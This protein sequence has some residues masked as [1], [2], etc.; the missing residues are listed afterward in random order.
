M[1]LQRTESRVS[2]RQ[3]TEKWGVGGSDVD[4]GEAARAVTGE[5]SPECRGG[6]PPSLREDAPQAS[7]L[8]T[9]IHGWTLRRFGND[10][11]RGGRR[12]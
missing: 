9:V 12:R 2:A 11:Q 7:H 1:P 10:L 4:S 8:S 3:V 5:T 6:A